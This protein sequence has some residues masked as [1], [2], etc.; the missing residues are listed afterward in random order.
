MKKNLFVRVDT[1]PEIGTGHILRCVG[2]ADELRNTFDKII[3][4]SRKTT[5]SIIEIILKNGFE[6]STI[7]TPIKKSLKNNSKLNNELETK[8]I[9]YLQ[10]KLKKLDLT[11]YNSIDLKNHRRIIRALE[12]TISSGKP[13]SSYLK[14]NKDLMRKI[15]KN[16]SIHL[17]APH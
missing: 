12:V 15:I 5:R 16:I 17:W 14:K 2:L 3:F 10:N 7:D 13:Y 8:G 1:S 11:T 4:L 6:V 9:I